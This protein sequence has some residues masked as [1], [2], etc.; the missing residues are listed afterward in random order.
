MSKNLRSAIGVIA[1][2]LAVAFLLLWVFAPKMTDESLTVQAYGW[3]AA[4][5]VLAVMYGVPTLSLLGLGILS[6]APVLAKK[7][8]PLERTLSLAG[9][10]IAGSDVGREIGQVDD[11]RLA[12]NTHRFTCPKCSGNVTYA[13]GVLP[14]RC[15][16]SAAHSWPHE[17][18]LWDDLDAVGNRADADRLATVV[19]ART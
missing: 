5:A 1:I 2:I 8:A 18:A 7:H 11:K 17:R 10:D 3:G 9:R 4:S 13:A 19:A 14:I 15:D 16:V 12:V 6:F